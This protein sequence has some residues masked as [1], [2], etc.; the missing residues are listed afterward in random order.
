MTDDEDDFVLDAAGNRVLIGLSLEETIEFEFLDDNIAA[1]STTSAHLSGRM[2]STR[3]KA[4]A[5]ALG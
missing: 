1:Q 3:R 2:A 4:L 5:C